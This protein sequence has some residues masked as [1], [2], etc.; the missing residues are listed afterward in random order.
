MSEGS[1][2]TM[3]FALWLPSFQF[4]A[5]KLVDDLLELRECS[6]QVEQGCSEVAT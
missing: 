5:L 6:D 2:P 1:V 3:D 4:K